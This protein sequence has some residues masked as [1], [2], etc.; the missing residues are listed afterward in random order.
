MT[1]YG[2]YEN[3]VPCAG[4][5]TGIEKIQGRECLIIANDATVKGGTYY[6]PSLSKNTCA[7]KKL[8][9]KGVKSSISKKWKRMMTL[10]KHVK[11]VEVG[12]RDGLQAESLILPISTRIQ[13]IN[14]LSE[15][16][17]KSI[18]VGSFVSPQ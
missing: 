16:G 1:A 13:L 3:Q 15:A 11:I 18:E 4:L 9:K 14:L 8:Q 6:L 2:L 10:S 5:I 17:F 12:P 7:L